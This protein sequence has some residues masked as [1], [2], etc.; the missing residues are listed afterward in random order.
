MK[1]ASENNDGG[2][3]DGIKDGTSRARHEA[4]ADGRGGRY[5]RV[6]APDEGALGLF[7]GEKRRRG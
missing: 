7:L 2:R 1:T 5:E 3:K 6:G 4:S